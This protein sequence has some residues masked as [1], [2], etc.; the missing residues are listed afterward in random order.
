M[1]LPIAN[2]S[3][4][5]IVDGIAFAR[6]TAKHLR[7]GIADEDDEARAVRHAVFRDR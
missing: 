3:Q 2:T 4:H 1:A 6:E 5:G 7:P